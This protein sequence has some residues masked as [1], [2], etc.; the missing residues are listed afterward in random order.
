MNHYHIQ[1]LE[2]QVLKI[3]QLQLFIAS[4]NQLFCHILLGKIDPLILVIQFKFILIFSY[5][6]IWN[7]G[8]QATD[9]ASSTVTS[10]VK[11]LGFINFNINKSAISNQLIAKD[12]IDQFN[13]NVK[14]RIFDTA[15]YIIPGLLKKFKMLNN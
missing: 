15:D 2:K 9:T 7:K 5:D 10:K 6:I 1:Q 3:S 13:D 11:G 12:M 14:F 4:Y 8:Y